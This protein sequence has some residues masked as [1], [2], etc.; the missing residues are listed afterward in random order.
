[1]SHD[2]EMQ[3]IRSDT[4]RSKANTAKIRLEI[5]KLKT[6]KRVKCT[7]YLERIYSTPQKLR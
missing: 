2:E 7:N 3:M 4:A 6:A 1:M 5:K